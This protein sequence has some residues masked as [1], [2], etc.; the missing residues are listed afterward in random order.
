MNLIFERNGLA[1][2]LRELGRAERIAPGLRELLGQAVF[3]TRD[4]ALDDLL[5]RAR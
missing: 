3:Q 5:G 4:P 2:Q 1:F